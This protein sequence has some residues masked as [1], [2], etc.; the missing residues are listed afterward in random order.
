[1][2]R[3]DLLGSFKR[4]FRRITKR[5]W[6]VKKLDSIVT[7]LRRDEPLPPNARPHRLTSDWEGFWECHIAPDWLLIY[8]MNDTTVLLARTGTHA[9]L[10][11]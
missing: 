1:M 7:M 3:L 2:K 5:K 10:F 9:D 8:D 11:E 4:D 6:D